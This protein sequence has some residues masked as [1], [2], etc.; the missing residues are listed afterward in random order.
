MALNAW[1]IRVES[2]LTQSAIAQK[3]GKSRQWLVNVEQGATAI[4]VD[5]LDSLASALGVSPCELLCTPTEEDLDSLLT[6]TGC[7]RKLRQI[8]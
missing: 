8:L 5:A 3:A 2:N 6:H 4:D 1:R 7:V